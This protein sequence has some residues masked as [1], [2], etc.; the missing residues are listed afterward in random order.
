MVAKYLQAEAVDA[1][2]QIQANGFFVH[3]NLPFSPSRPHFG[4][5]KAFG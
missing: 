4:P 3:W 5:R 1:A 2:I